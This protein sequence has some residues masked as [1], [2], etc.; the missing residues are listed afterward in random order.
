MRVIMNQMVLVT[1]VLLLVLGWGCNSPST[2]PDSAELSAAQP[3]APDAVQVKVEKQVFERIDE[4]GTADVIVLLTEKADLSAAPQITDWVERGEYVHRQLSETARRSQADLLGYLEK[5]GFEYRSYWVINAVLVKGG[6]LELVHTLAGLAGVKHIYA[7]SV[8]ALPQP[9]PEPSL[10]AR[11]RAVEWGIARIRADQAWADFG[12]TGETIIVANIDSGVQ[13]DHPALVGQYRGTLGPDLYDHNYNWFDPSNICSPAGVPCD[14]NDHGTHTMGTIVGAEGENQIGVAPGAKWIAAKGCETNTCSD[15]A[16]LASGEWIVAPTDLAGENPRPDLRPHVVN[17]SWGG[18]GGDAYYQEVVDAWIAAGIFPSI[19]SGNSGPSCNTV[20]SPGDYLNSYAVGSFDVNDNIASTSSR[21]AS[22]FDDEIKP[23]IAAPGVNVRSS[24]PGD[25]YANFSGTSMAAPHVSGS[26]ALL[27]SAAPAMIGD[28][29]GLIEILDQTAIDREDLTCGGTAQNNNVW[30]EGILDVYAA[31]E[32]APIGPTGILA[33]TITDGDTAAPI[34][35]ATVTV[36]GAADRT[37]RTDP[38]GLYD[39]RLPVGTYQVTV[40]AFGY[41]G[42]T[43]SGVLVEEDVTTTRDIALSAAPTHTV[44]GLIVDE[45]GAPL[46]G[47]VVMIPG[48]PLAAATTDSDGLYEI[49]GVPAGEYQLTARGRGQCFAA[50]TVALV[51]VDADVAVDFSLIRRVDAFGYFCDIPAVDYIE[52]EE[53]LP[54]SG[55]DVGLE[56]E[57]PFPFTFYGQSY[58]SAYICS[59][60]YMSFAG[61]TCGYANGS[62]PSSSAPNATIYPFWDDLNVDGESSVR[63]QLLGQEPERRF[64]VEWRNVRFYVDANQRLDFEIVLFEDGRILTQYR[65]LDQSG[66]EGGDS[67][68]IGLENESGDVAFLYGFNEAVLENPQFAILYDL[69]PMATVRGGV[70]DANDGLPIS[71]AAVQLLDG[72]GDVVRETTTDSDGAYSLLAPL[73]SYTVEASAYNYAPAATNVVLETTGQVVSHDF[74]LETARAEL[75]PLAL[76]FVVPAGES[77]T[78]T[79]DLTN[80]GGLDLNWEVFEAGGTKASIPAKRSTLTRNEKFDPNAQS[81]EGMYLDGHTRGWS[82]TAEGDVLASWAPSGMEIPWGVGY[83]G[84][85]WLSDPL[86]SPYA[87]AEFDVTG[88]ALNRFDATWAGGWTGDLAYDAG[89]HLLCQVIVGAD[90]GIHCWNPVTG[91]HVD[92]IE[93]SFAWTAISQRGLAYRADDDTFYVGGWNEGILYKVK[94]LGWDVPGE[95]LHQCSPS[96]PNISGLAYNGASQS[97]WMATNSLTDTI[98]QINPE[99][100]ETLSTL[101]HPNTDGYKGAG[102]AMDDLGNLWMVRQSDPQMAYLVESGVP[103]FS[104]VPWLSELPTSGTLAPGMTETIEVVVDA[105]DLDVGVY[106]A[107]LFFQTNSGRIAQLKVPVN[108]VVPAYYQAVDVGSRIEYIDTEGYRWAPD[109]KWEQGDW[110][111]VNRGLPRWTW[112]EIGETED[113]ELYQTQRINPYAYRFDRLPQGTYQVELKFAELTRWVRPGQRLFDVII[114]NQLMIPAYDIAFEVGTLTADTREFVIDPQ[115]G[116]L[117]I[118]LV[119]RSWF[120]KPVIN[121]IRV[122]HRPDL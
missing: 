2:D 74:L 58:A 84:N 112:R 45:S 24:V 121:A 76:T 90:N 36:A 83:T 38:A 53:V 37:T 11:V 13:F 1:G 115:D 97:V 73:G 79:L 49:P 52:A 93:G 20:G 57:L 68:T 109:Q 61:A 50:Q 15:S 118:R 101:A 87:N 95:V 14:N 44:T 54:L 22:A 100:C 75:D 116:R 56:I 117:D 10:T 98:Y 105:T 4:R 8:I 34:A 18:P 5:E 94:G 122:I 108:L 35:D 42:V 64:V 26:V 104:D 19:S 82:P 81:T 120:Y 28:I 48:T 63:S 41:T 85:V 69:P 106:Q 88:A 55:D 43:V 102:L 3:V 72:N 86:S 119:N 110:G 7:D 65:N 31:L 12:I 9:E 78:L 25:T 17:N 46:A 107:T 113:S 39:L 32:L 30:G 51:V 70:I 27:L 89:R 103:A 40:E 77:K 111:Y 29:D 59:N 99:T 47:A 62:I 21:G 6:T 80:T 67:A 114:E 71:G 23:D 92:S 91:D 16:L 33:G 66:M 96:D 60:G